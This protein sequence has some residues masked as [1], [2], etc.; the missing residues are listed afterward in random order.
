MLW[1]SVFGFAIGSERFPSVSGRLRKK[2]EAYLESLDDFAKE[3]IYCSG[4]T[5]VF[6]ELSLRR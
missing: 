5:Q 4:V 1:T 3:V 6:S 2:K